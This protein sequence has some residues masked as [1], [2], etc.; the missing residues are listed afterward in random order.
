MKT[1]IVTLLLL[2]C[3]SATSAFAAKNT[4]QITGLVKDKNTSEPLA[5]TTVAVRNWEETVVAATTTDEQGNFTLESV[6]YG[7]YSIV[8]SF[9]GYKEFRVEEVEINSAKLTLDPVLLEEDAETLEAAVVV[10][11]VPVIEQKLDKIVM[12]VAEAVSTQGSNALEVLRKAPGV[13]IDMDGNVKLNGQAVSVWIDGRPSYLSGLELEALLRSTDGTTIDKIELMAHP[14]AKYDA[15]G[16]GGIINIKM[17]KNVLQ[18]FNGTVN[19]AYGAMMYDRYLQ[20]GSGGFNLNY[21]GKKTST[22][23]NYSGRY[24]GMGATL[25][26]DTKM[27]ETG[28]Y[29]TS[30]S[31][32]MIEQ[33]SHNVKLINDVFL[34]KKHTVGFIV[35]GLVQDQSQDT[36]GDNNY[37]KLFLGDKLISNQN[38]I[39]ETKSDYNNVLANVNYTGLFKE[40]KAQELTLNVDYGYYD[41]LSYNYQDNSPVGEVMP[42]AGEIFRQNGQQY[43]NMV[44]G[45][46]DY[47]QNV[48]GNGMLEVGAKWAATRTAND[49]MREDFHAGTWE[50]NH[51]FSNVFN[52][53]EQVAAGYATFGKMFGSKWMAKIGLRGE[54]TYSVGNWLSVGQRSTKNYFDVF[55]TIFA[56]YNPSQ[57]WRFTLSYTNRISRPSF[58]QLNPFRTYVDANSY[59]EG[60]PDLDPQ[61]SDQLMVAVGFKNHY[62]LV[63][64]GSRT[65]NLIMQNPY[66]DPETA[67]KR[68][69]YENFGTQT[70]AG[71]ALSVSELPVTKWM[72]LTLTGTALYTSNIADPNLPKGEINNNGW[73]TQGFGQLTFLLP[74]DWKVELGGIITGKMPYGY[75]VVD[76]VFLT[77]G[78]V[79]KNF[80]KDRATFSLNV[81]DLFRTFESNLSYD[82]Q[83]VAYKL[84]QTM[85]LQKVR[86]GLSIRFGQSKATRARKVGTFDEDARVGTSGG[87]ST[88]TS[89]AGTM[90]GLN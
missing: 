83:G 61:Y 49:L 28:I 50:P 30:H 36:Y 27:K 19:A 3:V 60:N 43:I 77:F 76:P 69:Y 6:P 89:G 25:D 20:E 37:T 26:S 8:F 41:I 48:W 73:I 85:N 53:T 35:S 2:I 75:F 22:T 64:L 9:V 32:F 47:Q 45:K 52:Y 62:N 38:S 63:L 31:D 15:E 13:T 79:K 54:Y 11:K 44:S 82:Y 88:G 86:V 33:K 39:I 14:S 65:K 58:N 16:S 42:G 21:R 46:A 51:S 84:N 70:M 29:Q 10:A 68:L 67:E 7:S 55:P 81:T 87:I 40:D 5:Y 78:G 72:T 17:K 57:N 1:K 56:G 80:W 74:K 12:N 18:G 23:L 34:N 4:C 66:Y 59:T 24:D 71:A 90:G